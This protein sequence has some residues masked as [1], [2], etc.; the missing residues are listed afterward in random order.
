MYKCCRCKYCGRNQHEH[1]M[2]PNF[3]HNTFQLMLEC[4]SKSQISPSPPVEVVVVPL[5]IETLIPIKQDNSSICL[6]D[7][8]SFLTN[9]ASLFV[10]S[11]ISDLED[12]FEDLMTVIAQL[13]SH[14][15]CLW[16]LFKDSFHWFLVFL[17]SIVIGH[18]LDWFAALSSIMDIEAF[19]QFLKAHKVWI[20]IPTSST[21]GSGFSYLQWIDFFQRGDM[22]FVGS[23]SCFV[24]RC[25]SLAWDLLLHWGH[26][27]PHS[28][29]YE[30]IFVVLL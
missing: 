28:L 25:S 12:T 16:S 26:S 4:A 14:H 10:E 9:I 2:C 19:E 13:L 7:Q 18:L 21:Y 24:F 3:S 11:H 6:P 17:S 8:D 20:W 15:V 22:L 1:E 30:G 29:S 5:L 23:G 27:Y